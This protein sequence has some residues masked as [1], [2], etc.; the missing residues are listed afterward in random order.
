MRLKSGELL[1]WNRRD[2]VMR[3]M[4]IDIPDEEA[5][6]PIRV[7]SPRSSERRRWSCITSGVF[8]VG[9]HR[10]KDHHADQEGGEPE[11]ENQMEVLGNSE[12]NE[13]DLC[14][15]NHHTEER[16]VPTPAGVHPGFP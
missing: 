6:E 14:E 8:G 12:G 4:E 9:H 3:G 7:G 16:E 2:Q 15:D 10:R 5:D 11:L 13:A 1:P